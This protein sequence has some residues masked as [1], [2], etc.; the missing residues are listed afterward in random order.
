MRD[1]FRLDILGRDFSCWALQQ[2]IHPFR[3]Q[4]TQVECHASFTRAKF[5]HDDLLVRALLQADPQVDRQR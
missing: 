5:C 2:A 3:I 4:V 1:Q